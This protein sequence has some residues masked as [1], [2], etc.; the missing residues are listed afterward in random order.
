M[1][2]GRQQHGIDPSSGDGGDPAAQV[3]TALNRI[4]RRARRSNTERALRLRGAVGAVVDGRLSEEE[5]AAAVEAAH[6]LIGSAGTFGFRRAS[7]L[8][9]ELEDFFVAA[10]FAM[11]ERVRAAELLVKDLE[12][13]LASN[14]TETPE[15]C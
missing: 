8:A 15:D 4:G 9:G 3:R 12:Q 2:D 6:Q 10:D 7:D 13:E 1:I 11:P 5:R 14:P